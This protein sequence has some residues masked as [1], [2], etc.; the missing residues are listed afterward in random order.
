MFIVYRYM[1]SCFLMFL[2]NMFVVFFYLFKRYHLTSRLNILHILIFISSTL[3]NHPPL[4]SQASDSASKLML[5]DDAELEKV[6]IT[7]KQPLCHVYLWLSIKSFIC[8]SVIVTLNLR[9]ALES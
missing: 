3:F 4:M 6:C 7:V 1:K 9:A 2:F 8:R 5:L